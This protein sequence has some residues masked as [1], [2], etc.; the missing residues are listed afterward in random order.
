MH[1]NV[2]NKSLPFSNQAAVD[3]PPGWHAVLSRRR[4]VQAALTGCATMT[5]GTGFGLPAPFLQD[6][7]AQGAPKTGGALAMN[8]WVPEF[9]SFDPIAG[10]AGANQIQWVLYDQ[11]VR[12]GADLASVEPA[13]AEG[14]EISP[15]GLTYTFTLRAATF[16]DGSPVTAADVVYSLD[17]VRTAEGTYMN[18]TLPPATIEAPDE[19]TVVVRLERLFA[20][21]L[22]VLV[23]A[24]ASILPRALVEGQKALFFRNP[25]GAGP[26]RLESWEQTGPFVF[27]RHE[28]YWDVGKPYLDRLTLRF[29]E[30]P[31]DGAT[32]FER[33]DLDIVTAIPGAE[34]ATFRTLPDA[35]VQEFATTG[36]MFGLINVARPPFDDKALRQ[37]M[38]YAVDKQAIV[39]ELLAGAGEAQNTYIPQVAGHDDD[40]PGYPFNLEK[41]GELVAGSAGRGGFGVELLTEPSELGKKM[42]ALI[43]E[44]LARIGGQVTILPSDEMDARMRAQDFDLFVIGAGANSPAD[45]DDIAVLARS[46]VAG[47]FFGYQNERVDE[48]LAAAT[49]TTDW[50]ERA[51]H[52]KEAQAIV[53]EDAPFLFLVYPTNVAAT[54]P[55]VHGFAGQGAIRLFDIWRDDV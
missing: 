35:V 21:L 4:L 51:D 30:A 55:Y 31:D 36:M 18:S 20:P 17:R 27:A 50:A 12:V 5:L 54:K 40:A 34:I 24:E 19:R 25:I 11:L 46:D 45:P 39:D 53:A 23:A 2:G 10:N 3:S 6:A 29:V 44:H 43:A 33:G 42:G 22:S 48:A 1:P 14:W 32:L 26:F 37:A 9:G 7:R 28:G 41:A 49:G 38:N 8:M 47:P 52:Y 13:L 16:H 15:D